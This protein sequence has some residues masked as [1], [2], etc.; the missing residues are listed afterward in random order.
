MMQY[1]IASSGTAM[2]APAAMPRAQVLFVPGK[3]LARIDPRVG[4]EA[5]L[6]ESV[7]LEPNNAE[8]LADLAGV[9]ESLGKTAEVDA[10]YD[11]ALKLAGNDPQPY[12]QAAVRYVSSMQE[13]A[14]DGVEPPA[15]QVESVRALATKALSFAPDDALANAVLGA[16]YTFAGEDARK[17]IAAS[18]RAIQLS[19]AMIDVAAD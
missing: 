15:E 9:K 10:L 3:R 18:S 16:T 8:A 17:G 14:R 4:A 2:G 13:Q 1:S 7:K 19:P 5:F 6:A 11:R 12:V